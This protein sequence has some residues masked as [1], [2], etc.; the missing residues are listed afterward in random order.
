M[1]LLFRS[2]PLVLL[3]Y[4]LRLQSSEGN[5]NVK[6]SY[7]GGSSMEEALDVGRR[8]GDDDQFGVRD[9]KQY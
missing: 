3:I 1:L 6:I 7:L 2:L 5:S 9:R 8:F 4:N